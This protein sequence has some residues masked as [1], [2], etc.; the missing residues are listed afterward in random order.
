MLTQKGKLTL[1]LD[2]RNSIV[3]TLPSG[4]TIEIQ[5]SDDSSGKKRKA[6]ITVQAS[7]SIKIHRATRRTKNEV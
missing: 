5:L 6:G 2:W 7:R 3:L 1:T 4:E